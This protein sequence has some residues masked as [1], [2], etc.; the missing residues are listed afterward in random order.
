[1]LVHIAPLNWTVGGTLR[2]LNWLTHSALGAP[3]PELLVFAG[4][5]IMY[6][7]EMQSLTDYIF[8]IAV[9]TI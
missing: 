3:I 4:N 2:S 6:P 7:I 1:M 8:P 5:K 9:L